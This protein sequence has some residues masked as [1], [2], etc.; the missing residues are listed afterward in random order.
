M[1]IK[2]VE[3]KRYALVLAAL[4]AIGGYLFIRF[5]DRVNL[6]V[7]GVYMAIGAVAGW[8]WQ[9]YMSHADPAWPGWW[10]APERV[11]G[12]FLGV[13]WEDWAFYPICGGLFYF[14]RMGFGVIVEYFHLYIKRNH[15]AMQLLWWVLVLIT[16][17]ACSIFADGG[18]SIAWWFA[19]PGIIMMAFN[20]ERIDFV[21]FVLTGAFIILMAAGWDLFVPD[22]SYITESGQHSKVWLNA[23]WAWIHGKPVE[24]MPW[25]AK[26]GWI[27]IYNLAVTCER[28][29]KG[30]V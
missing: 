12:Y 2:K 10:Y 7:F 23:D 26:S 28:I 22:W 4:A 11:H 1:Q 20:L 21:Q 17:A 3:E 6:A 19:I 16:F 14:V 8:T 30:K 27:F 18:V 15:L 25:F 24:I 9:L 13:S 5:R 29:G